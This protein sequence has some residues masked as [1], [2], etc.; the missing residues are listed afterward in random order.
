MDLRN[1]K[2]H[3]RMKRHQVLRALVDAQGFKFGA[4]VGVMD[5]TTL[6]HLLDKCPMLT[7]YGVDKWE[8]GEEYASKDMD[9]TRSH[10][11]YRAAWYKDRCRILYGDS[12]EMADKV[13]DR[14]LDFV[15][16]DAAHDYWSVCA[17]IQAWQPKLNKRGVMLGHD[18]DFDGVVRAVNTLFGPANY[19]VLPDDVWLH[20]PERVDAASTHGLH[21]NQPAAPQGNQGGPAR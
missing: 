2:F 18:I 19:R 10:V 12:Q 3:K 20:I 4:E 17:D 21:Q 1:A 9:Y 14:S 5:G 15:F 8:A 6:F 16:I 11:M 13:E 7:M